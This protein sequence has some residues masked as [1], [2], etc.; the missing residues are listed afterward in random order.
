VE[1][2][3]YAEERR[4]RDTFSIIGNDPPV[5]GLSGPSSGDK[6]VG[7]S[8]RATDRLFPPIRYFSDACREAIDYSSLVKVGYGDV[9]NSLSS[10]NRPNR[11]HFDARLS[12]PALKLPLLFAQ[13]NALWVGVF[14]SSINMKIAFVGKGGSGKTTISALFTRYVASRGLPVI[15]IDA[16]I[17][18]QLPEALGM[19]EK[20]AR[21]LKPMGAEID[22]IK[23]YVRGCNPRIASRDVMIKTTPPGAGS[24]LIAVTEQNPIYDYF[25]QSFKG[26]RVMVA[27]PYTEDD[28]GIKCYHSKT[29]AVELFLNHLID[30]EREYVVT[31][32]TAGADS[33]ASGLFTRFDVTFI[34]VEPTLKSLGV[35]QQYKH[36]A[37]DY[38]VTLKVVAN[39]VESD[40]DVSFIQQ[41]VGGDY[42][43][44]FG[45]SRY[46]RQMEKGVIGDM[47]EVET[48]NMA[49]LENLLKLVD[50]RKKDWNKFYRQAVE[51]HI[52]NAE[53]WAN[54]QL[55]TNVVNQIDP[56]FNM[57]DMVNAQLKP[58][59]MSNNNLISEQTSMGKEKFHVINSH[60]RA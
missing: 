44:S 14:C 17:N 19:T 25:T 7:C 41:R 47:S 60:S 23:E 15:A 59:F 55:G 2:A 1:V 8:L 11:R 24:R 27:G 51:F 12:I 37:S 9:P 6:V 49:A 38:D 45:L 42:L 10:S 30:G 5:S 58:A 57:E 50:K 21:V 32:M 20:Q 33:F 36:H 26:I 46:V 18:Q 29:G 16:D 48:E 56:A 53:S 34:V 40:E 31:D 43:T 39:K 35:Y 3:I 52:K 13:F 22:L 28:L 54:A 4:R